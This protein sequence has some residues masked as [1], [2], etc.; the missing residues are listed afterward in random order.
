MINLVVGLQGKLSTTNVCK[1]INSRSAN[2]QLIANTYLYNWLNTNLKVPCVWALKVI[3]GPNANS[4]P[5]PTDAEKA[6]TPS[7][8]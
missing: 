1:A 3:S 7:F 4:D 2:D 5:F 8:K 6:A